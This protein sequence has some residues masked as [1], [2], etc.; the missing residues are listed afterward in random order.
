MDR[1]RKDGFDANQGSGHNGVHY[2]EGSIVRARLRN[3]QTYK[4]V[5]FHPGPNLNLI[6][7]PN[8]SGKSTIVCAIVLGLGGKPSTLG[9][10]SHA[11][12]Y[13][14]DK[15]QEGS[16][17]LE[18]YRKDQPNYV[19]K[20]SLKRDKEAYD[21]T[22]NGKRITKQDAKSIISGLHIDVE[23]LCQCLPQEKV[24]DFAKM[25]PQQILQSTQK[26]AGGEQMLQQHQE[27][28]ELGK[29]ERSYESTMVAKSDE[30]EKCQTK[31]E[32]L[33]KDYDRY[34]QQKQR[35]EDLKHMENKKLWLE[36]NEAKKHVDGFKVQELAVKDKIKEFEERLGPIKKKL[37]DATAKKKQH[38]ATYDS[39]KKTANN[40]YN[41]FMNLTEKVEDAAAQMEQNQ[42]DVKTSTKSISSAETKLQKLQREGNDLTIELKEAMDKMASSNTAD[43]M[44]AK[45]KE[46]S[47]I[48]TN[49]AR[50]DREQKK[51]LVEYKQYATKVKT[52][53]K[54]KT[55]IEN[56]REQRE[57]S[58]KQRSSNAYNLMMWLR[59]NGDA[60]EK[61]VL[62][63]MSVLIDMKNPMDIPYV[64]DVVPKMDF[65]AFIVQT[66]HDHRRLKE[67]MKKQ[68]FSVVIAQVAPT[69]NQSR[70]RLDALK[71][72]Y[73]KIQVV[74]DLFTAPEPIKRYLVNNKRVDDIPILRETPF[75]GI[76]NQTEMYNYGVTSCYTQDDT[77]LKLLKSSYGQRN[78]NV[79]TEQFYRNQRSKFLGASVDLDRK[80]Q[81]TNDLK[82]VKDKQ[83]LLKDSSED[84][85]IEAGELR[86]REN[87]LREELAQLKADEKKITTIQRSIRFTEQKT[88]E[89][90]AN[91]DQV[92][93]ELIELTRNFKELCR[94]YVQ[95]V[96]KM[97]DAT[98]KQVEMNNKL[99]LEQLTV[100]ELDGVLDKL[101]RENQE[102]QNQRQ[103]LLA[104]FTTLKQ[105]RK[106][107][108]LIAKEK[109]Q[110]ARNK[111]GVQ[112]PDSDPAYQKIYL[113]IVAQ[114]IEEITELIS[115]EQSM[116]EAQ[117]EAD[118]N[119]VTEYEQVESQTKEA[120]I[121]FEKAQKA[122]EEADARLKEI[123][124]TWL[125]QLNGLVAKIN[126]EFSE[127]FER[128][129]FQG[130]IE[131]GKP[132]EEEKP[133]FF[134]LYGIVIKVA[135]R[136]EESMR[137]L[138]AAVQSGGEKSVATMLY[139]M[140]LQQVTTC[141][142]RIVDEINQGMDQRNERAVY[143]QI[144]A[145]S[146][147]LGHR[148]SQYFLITPKLLQNLEYTP[149]M[150]VINIFAGPWLYADQWLTPPQQITQLRHVIEQKRR[151]LQLGQ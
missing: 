99:V 103:V 128:L 26:A 45:K 44:K 36:Y 110:K 43:V 106:E 35:Q 59:E 143:S 79:T 11:Y 63:P 28:I 122:H 78:V 10:H 49:L 89:T 22:L 82:E 117:S 114:T 132:D 52:L 12:E 32:S 37:D 90:Q 119:I 1:K 142:F 126:V 51:I 107:S 13:I 124:D 62:P 70:I 131:L 14:N 94:K 31:L 3:I 108:V 19:L 111:T 41:S 150:R 133:N 105:M 75:N 68:N 9:R 50:I 58:L 8:G 4:D 29:S 47:E 72:M 141:P 61:E 137:A 148:Q 33:Q 40:S 67:E 80:K 23:N 115:Q 60:F 73:G 138:E 24:Q 146:E 56:V 98:V 92:K 93:D 25:N 95:L 91:L 144:L 120:K 42:S 135:Y 97:K 87:T 69:T 109:L 134:E 5:E 74:G 125:P 139:L 7:G 85:K 71:N 147:K 136:Q 66:S 6:I 16:I 100:A 130:E 127:M 30:L 84:I 48:G 104:E 38:K 129:G 64:E 46:M 145:C 57:Q 2:Q 55:N 86:R 17:E 102:F 18:L 81:I 149:T 116:L 83:E 101:T 112:M 65:D 53:E 77:K 118:E 121:D 88:T 54:E 15:E 20:R 76:K 39:T 96:L 140:A 27:L 34:L 113:S 21:A 151:R 123:K